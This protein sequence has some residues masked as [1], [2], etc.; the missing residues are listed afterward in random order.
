MAVNGVNQISAANAWVMSLKKLQE[1]QRQ[2]QVLQK[3]RMIDMKVRAHEMAHL[4]A[5]QGIAVFGPY[6][7]YVR[8]PD[9]RMYAVGGEVNIDTSPVPGD[10]EKTIEKAEKIVRA[11]LAPVNPS[12]QDYRVAQQAEM[13]KQK[14][15]LEKEQ[16]EK[17]QEDTQRISV[18]V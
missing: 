16:E 1:E 2:Q 5:A 10:P 11:A 13:I 7:E 14:A 17:D 8:G 9:G 15:T 18:I 4:I 12:P 3:L 6:Y